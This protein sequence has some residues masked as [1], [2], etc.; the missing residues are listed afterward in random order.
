MV[1]SRIFLTRKIFQFNIDFS[2]QLT[3]IIEI[4][5]I[6]MFRWFKSPDHSRQVKGLL[7]EKQEIL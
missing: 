5:K 2:V 4:Q 7:T 3:P 1:S 6:I